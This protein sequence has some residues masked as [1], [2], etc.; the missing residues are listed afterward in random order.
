MNTRQHERGV[1]L[2]EAL[3][4]LAVMSF[5]MLGVVG[6]QASL[7]FNADASKQRSEAVRLAQEEIERWRNFSV[8]PTTPG[9]A[10]FED[11]AGG[12]AAPVSLPAAGNA[13]YSRKTTVT[14]LAA[15]DPALKNVTVTVNWL[16]RRAASSTDVQAVTL[17]TMIAGIAPEL[18]GSLGIPGDQ[19]A[20]Q[21]PRQRHPVIPVGA[22][23]PINQGT[24]STFSPPGGGS[25]VW[26]FNN[27]T[28]MITSTCNPTCD[29]FNYWF[30]SGVIHFAVSGMPTAL[31]AELPSGA[32]IVGVGVRV[33]QT[34]P[35]TQTVTCHTSPASTYV[36]YYCALRNFGS[37]PWSGRS[38]LTGIALAATLAEPSASLYK[39]CRYTSVASHTTLGNRN[40][41]HPLNYAAANSSLT[42]QNFLETSAGDN[43]VSYPFP[44]DGPEPLLNSTTFAHQPSS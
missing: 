16:D 32:A 41:E 25:L 6:M 7:R 21:R 9:M 18:A 44:G 17:T 14:P 40:A 30:L 5:G 37:N 23:N 33:L 15:G 24:I 2:I 42:N 43:T 10:A 20:T 26:V 28:G 39:V 4:A 12:A 34:A 8:L 29:G 3:V 19:A 38:E 35:L 22:I 27:A 36:T 1:S 31:M 11:I 13:S